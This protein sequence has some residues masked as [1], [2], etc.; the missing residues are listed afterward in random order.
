LLFLTTN[1][2]QLNYLI[3]RPLYLATCLFGIAFIIIGNASANT[4]SFGRH[5]LLAAGYSDSQ[6][7][8]SA[9][10]IA[11]GTIT[12]V[13]LLHAM[14]RK[15]G[16]VVNNVFAL[17]KIMI[18]VMII[19]T[20]FASIGGKAFG[21]EPPAATNLDP[22]NSFSGAQNEAY[23]YAQAYL[24]IVYTCAGFNQANYVRTTR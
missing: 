7:Q 12:A 6:I 11:L 21:T 18:L 22:Q 15:L 4:L 10:F 2:G 20:G 19:I 23:G 17:I 1:C 9:R 16:I 14:W 5:V 8:N 13:C 3:K 24:S